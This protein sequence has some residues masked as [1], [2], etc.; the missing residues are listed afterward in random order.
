[1]SQIANPA[2]LNE[3]QPHA[4]EEYR[5]RNVIGKRAAT[6]VGEMMGVIT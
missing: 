2:G 5:P 1:M 6:R 3:T 4:P